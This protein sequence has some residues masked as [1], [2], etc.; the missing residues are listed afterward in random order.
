MCI[1]HS[2]IIAFKL[3]G[4]NVAAL[5]VYRDINPNRTLTT[6][7]CKMPALLKCETNHFR[8]F[9]HYRILG[10]RLDRFHDIIFLVSHCTDNSSGFLQGKSSC[11]IIT[12]LAADYEHGNGV[13]P[14][15]YN[16]G[17]CICSAGAGCHT[18]SGN[19]IIQTGIGFCSN[20]T[21]LLVMII[22][23]MQAF[24]MAESIIQVHGTS[25]H[26]AENIRYSVFYKEICNIICKSN[27]H[28]LSPI[29]FAFSLYY[30]IPTLSIMTFAI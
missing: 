13:K 19:V 30:Q 21:C 29:S 4:L 12:D 6:R 23:N 22:G 18:D 7:S 28:S 25:A 8:F 17:Q 5:I 2:R 9:Y 3:F 26:N 16:T 24:V 11:S 15:A 20:S 27:F 10:H 14:T 1:I